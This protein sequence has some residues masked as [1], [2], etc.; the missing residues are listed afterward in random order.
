MQKINVFG[1]STC[2]IRP[3]YTQAIEDATFRLD[4]AEKDSSGHPKQER[5]ALVAAQ[6]QWSEHKAWC[7]ICRKEP[8]F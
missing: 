4:C 3:M 7:P 1:M 5:T 8:M 6:T 2:R